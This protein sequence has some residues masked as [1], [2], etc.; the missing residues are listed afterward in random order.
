MGKKSHCQ[1][2]AAWTPTAGTPHARANNYSAMCQC[3]SVSEWFGS[4]HCHYVSPSQ[5]PHMFD[6][7]CHL[8]IDDSVN[9]DEIVL[10]DIELKNAGHEMA[11]VGEPCNADVHAKIPALFITM[12]CPCCVYTCTCTEFSQSRGYSIAYTCAELGSC[13]KL[14][15]LASS[16]MKAVV[17]T[18][19]FKF[20]Q[21]QIIAFDSYFPRWPPQGVC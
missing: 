7:L 10:T 16:L 11:I 15:C 4:V 2:L 9:K 6:W 13:L 8:K 17:T 18:H 21:T 1:Q 3:D 20:Q 14:Y 12:L 19:S 5:I